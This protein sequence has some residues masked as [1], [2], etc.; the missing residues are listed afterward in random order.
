M[1][2]AD[3]HKSVQKRWSCQSVAG[4]LATGSK[5]EDEV[6]ILLVLLIKIRENKQKLLDYLIFIASRYLCNCILWFS[7]K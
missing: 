3:F 6:V 5:M 1:H 4:C 2:L 7:I